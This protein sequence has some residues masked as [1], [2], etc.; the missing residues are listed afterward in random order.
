[1]IISPHKVLSE[2]WIKPNPEYNSFDPDKDIQPNGIDL[3]L[4]EVFQLKHPH[5][6]FNPK[7]GRGGRTSNSFYLLKDNEKQHLAY[8]K[9]D[10]SHTTLHNHAD[11]SILK[12]VDKAWVLSGR[13]S[14]DFQTNMIVDIPNGIAASLIVRSTLNRNQ[15]FVTSGLYD[16]GFKGIVGGM[17]HIQHP[18]QSTFEQSAAVCQIIFYKSDITNKMYHGS[19]INYDRRQDTE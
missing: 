11:G 7:T 19:Y 9:I 17:L 1:M 6:F 10:I 15:M 16:S 3:R 18:F 13:N 2:G 12:K 5:D 8:Q 14:Y 4:E